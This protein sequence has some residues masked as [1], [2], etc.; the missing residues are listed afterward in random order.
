MVP[1]CNLATRK[2][3]KLTILKRSKE[4]VRDVLQPRDI[5]GEAQALFLSMV[6]EIVSL[7]PSVKTTFCRF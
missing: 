2:L 5:N 7:Y 6:R 3:D 1:S 4:F